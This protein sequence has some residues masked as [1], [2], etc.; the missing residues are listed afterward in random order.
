[1]RQFPHFFKYLLTIRRNIFSSCLYEQTNFTLAV[2]YNGKKAR[3]DDAMTRV[4]ML[5]TPSMWQGMKEHAKNKKITYS[6]Q[7][8]FFIIAYFLA[9]AVFF[10]ATLPFL[11]PF[12]AIVRLRYDNM[13]TAVIVGGLLGSLSFGLGQA[14][15]LCLQLIVFELLCRFKYYK[16]PASVAIGLSILIIQMPWQSVS[17]GGVPPFLVLL[18]VG[19]EVILAV[20]MTLFIQLFFVRPHQFWQTEWSYERIGAGFVIAAAMLGGMQSVVIY[21]LSL[22]IFTLH[23]IICIAA[24]VAGVPIAT[25]TAT[26]LGALLGVASLSFTG[27]LALYAVTGVVAGS[28]KR[29]G[30]LG[31]ALGSIVPS[32]LFFFYDATLPLDIVYFFSIVMAAILFL[33]LPQSLFTTLHDLFYPERDEV[34]LKRQTW[35]TEH[36]TENLMQFQHFVDFMKELVFD[37]F[38]ADYVQKK[39]VEPLATCM[40]C[41]RYERCWADAEMAQTVEGWCVAK[42]AAKPAEVLRTEEQ[43]RQKCVKSTKLLEELET[44]LYQEQ[45]NGQFYHGKKMI[46]LQLRDLS[47]HLQRLMQEI[48][49]EALSF[50]SIEEELMNAFKQAYIPCFQIDVLQSKPGERIVV[51]SLTPKKSSQYDMLQLCER[52]IVPIFYDVWQE[53]LFVE[54]YEIRQEPFRHMQV[55][56]RSAVRYELAHDS[57]S[58]AKELVNGSGDAHAIFPIHAG[59]TAVMLSDGMGQNKEAQR[60][61]RKLIRMM[62]ECLL[63]NMNPETAMH[64]LHYVMSL[65]REIDMYATID[66]ALI[67]L[68]NGTLWSWKAGSMSTYIVRGQTVMKI[69]GTSAPVGFMPQFSVETQKMKLRADDVI[70]MVSDGLFSSELNWDEQES[71]FL[72]LIKQRIAEKM[73]IDV[74]L[75]DVMAHY[76][77]RYEIEDDCTLIGLTLQ[78]IIPQWATVKAN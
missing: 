56:F 65:K 12:W 1:M 17:Y 4:E 32:A 61:S 39:K 52:L 24:R 11:L 36:A 57:Y 10:D 70:F 15:I 16:M 29:L 23:L 50:Q 43:V 47:R 8:T 37:R 33:L 74:L 2:L 19:Y 72:E 35:M 76:K 20:L 46:A 75:Y 64:T 30:R 13:R 7:V 40:S 3:G 21:S 68:Q 45:M 55:R 66:F 53:P 67:D 6:L 62:R 58:Q 73:P 25:M 78:H 77:G 48:K 26:I 44:Q 41:F 22:T 69:D 42:A 49:E 60:E 27:M 14:V 71:Y 18:Y 54:H 28:C 34:L 63:Y 31:V 51:C 5:E 9:Q 59:L 38:T